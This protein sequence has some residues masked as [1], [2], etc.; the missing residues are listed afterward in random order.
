MNE[1]TEQARKYC[2]SYTLILLDDE[3]YEKNTAK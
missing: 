2:C 3:Y 1:L